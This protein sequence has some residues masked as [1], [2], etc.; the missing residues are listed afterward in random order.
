MIRSN[1]SKPKSAVAKQERD[2]WVDEVERLAADVEKW[3]KTRDWA[4]RRELKNFTED[5]IGTYQLPVLTVLTAL[6]RVVFEPVAR[7]V[8]G[9][10]GRIDLYAFPSFS[11]VVLVRR[12][13]KWIFLSDSDH[14]DLG[15][16]WKE[17]DFVETLS[18]L[19]A[20]A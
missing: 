10:S 14:S 5:E 11:Q 13:R 4:V 9:G 17:A 12:G 20:A 1:V 6:G 16:R 8:A 19:Q 18:E 15:R 3:A 7:F 2:S